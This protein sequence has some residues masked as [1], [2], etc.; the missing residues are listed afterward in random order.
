MEEFKEYLWGLAVHMGVS[1]MTAISECEQ[2]RLFSVPGTTLV[3]HEMGEKFEKKLR[4]VLLNSSSI[5]IKM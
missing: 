2:M 4:Y 1:C 5:Y 3:T